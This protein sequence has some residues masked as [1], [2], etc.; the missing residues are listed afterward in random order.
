[1][2]IQSTSM[3]SGFKS[4][5]EA[6]DWELYGAAMPGLNGNDA[7]PVNSGSCLAVRPDSC[8]LYTSWT[9]KW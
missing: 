4:A 5:S 2:H 7:V 9:R 6:G 3:L 1:M 8:L